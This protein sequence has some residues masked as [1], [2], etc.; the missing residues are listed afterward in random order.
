MSAPT[1]QTAPPPIPMRCW[2]PGSFEVGVERNTL[3][4][5]AQ[6]H[7][8]DVKQERGQKNTEGKDD[9]RSVRSNAEI[10]S[11]SPARPWGRRAP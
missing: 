3:A 10:S 6:V 7:E 2:R 5:D 11:H 8:V 4:E 1:P 9:H